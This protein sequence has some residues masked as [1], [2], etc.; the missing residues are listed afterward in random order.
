MF[1]VAMI[2]SHPYIE[3]VA[4]DS[5]GRIVLMCLPLRTLF[6]ESTATIAIGISVTEARAIVIGLATIDIVAIGLVLER[7][8]YLVSYR[9]AYGLASAGID[10]QGT[11]RIVIARACSQPL[12][13]IQ[14]INH[15]LVGIELRLV[16]TGNDHAQLLHIGGVE[17]FGLEEQVIDI[18]THIR[19]NG[20]GIGVV[21]EATVPEHHEML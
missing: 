3:V 13:L 21:T 12:G 18:D 7:V 5:L 15:H 8:A 2:V 16:V 1:E 14:E 4:V 11:H 10:P 19:R 17:L 6:P 9:R 20:G